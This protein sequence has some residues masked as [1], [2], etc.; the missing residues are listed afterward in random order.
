MEFAFIRVNYFLNFFI[1]VNCERNFSHFNSSVCSKEKKKMDF[2]KQG[3]ALIAKDE[4]EYR[5][6]GK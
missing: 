6:S 2:D 5:N 3:E 4:P 1:K